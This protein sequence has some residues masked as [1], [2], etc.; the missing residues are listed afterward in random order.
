MELGEL[1]KATDEDYLTRTQAFAYI[2]QKNPDALKDLKEL[3]KIASLLMVD[4]LHV[5][6]E[7]GV[8]QYSS[9]PKY[10]GLDFHKGKQMRAFLPLLEDTTGTKYYVQKEQPNTAEGKIMKYVGIARGNPRGIIQIG[11]APKR[12][13]DA[14]DK[15]E[16]FEWNHR[17]YYIKSIKYEKI[18]ICGIVSVKELYRNRIFNS[19]ILSVYMILLCIVVTIFLDR[20]LEKKLIRGIH[21]ILDG[22]TKIRKGNLDTRISVE[23]NPELIELSAGINSMVDSILYEHEHDSL[24]RLPTYHSFKKM[25]EKVME[26]KNRGYAAG[27]MIDLDKFKAVN[28]TYGHDFGDEYLKYMAEKMRELP[29]QSCIISRRSGDEFCMFIYG[30]ADREQ[31]TNQ[32]EEFWDE[33]NSYPVVLPDGKISHLVASGGIAFLEENTT[34]ARMMYDADLALYEAKKGAPGTFRIFEGNN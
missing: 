2:I 14:R 21:E 1:E 7:N 9:I 13:M 29:E 19:L 5:S 6:D 16:I 10:I 17:K 23:G 4:E 22:L 31:L 27:I 34:F 30:Y 20:L 8:I 33:L 18:W 24:T 11:L 3:K 26:E 25:V 32:I 12:L 15:G 28:D